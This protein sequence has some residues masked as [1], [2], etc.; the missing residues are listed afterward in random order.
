MAAEN[1]APMQLTKKSNLHAPGSGYTI[2]KDL[3]TQFP[4]E[5]SQIQLLTSVCSHINREM[6]GKGV[7]YGMN[8]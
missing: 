3:F 4:D 2:T 7:Y 1:T 6:Q 5:M 8:D